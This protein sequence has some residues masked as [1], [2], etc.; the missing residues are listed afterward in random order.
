MKQ[1]IAITCLAVILTSCNNAEPTKTDADSTAAAVAP[2]TELVLPFKLERPYRNW[3]KGSNENVVA[4]MTALKT[5]VDKDFTT[6]AGT[7]GDSLEMHFD[8]FYA[9]LSRDSALKMFAAMR[10]QYNDL[11]VTMYDYESV[12]SADKS[13]EWVTLWYKEAWKNE[14]GVADSL[15]ITDDIKLKDGKMITLDEKIQHIP[16]KK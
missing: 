8:N 15:A 16:A 5:Y 7:I 4:A 6:M 3:Q 13:E 11:T 1:I 9:K 2:A 10:P 14:K 12:I